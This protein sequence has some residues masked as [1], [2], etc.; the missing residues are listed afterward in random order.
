MSNWHSTAH[1][2]QRH[3]KTHGRPAVGEPTYCGK[4]ATRVQVV[5]VGTEGVTCK[6]C[7]KRIN[8]SYG[9]IYSR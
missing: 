5:T 7:N 9:Y 4:D 2:G 8:E 3:P 6:R 1:L